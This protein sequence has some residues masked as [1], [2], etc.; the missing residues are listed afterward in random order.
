LRATP[1]NQLDVKT[2]RVS[3]HKREELLFREKPTEK[4]NTVI[5]EK[6][7]AIFVPEAK[8]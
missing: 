4:D 2:P 8:P 3:E 6:N 7:H 5:A 1:R